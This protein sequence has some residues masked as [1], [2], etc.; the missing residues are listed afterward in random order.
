VYPYTVAPSDIW[1]YPTRTLT[2]RFTIIERARGYSSGLSKVLDETRYFT[3]LAIL[4][5]GRG[6]IIRYPDDDIAPSKAWTV[7]TTPTDGVAPGCVTDH[8]DSTRCCWDIPASTESDLL[9]VDLGSSMTGILRIIILTGMTCKVYASNDKTTWTNVF[10]QAPGGNPVEY[11][12]Y[13]NGYRYLKFS[14][15]NPETSTYK[16][17]WYTIEFYPDNPLPYSRDLAYS[18]RVWVFVYNGYYQ[19]LEVVSV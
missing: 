10:S 18:G 11:F 16:G 15:Q 3:K 17:Y 5:S 8:N 1:N 7:I 2:E 13:I 14:I 19:L 9:M 4:G 6:A 12:I